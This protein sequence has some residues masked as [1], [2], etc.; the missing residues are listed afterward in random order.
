[1]LGQAGSLAEAQTRSEEGGLV[2]TT[3]ISMRARMPSH[4][5]YPPLVV[6]ANY[7]HDVLSH[8]NTRNR[9]LKGS[10][11]TES[12]RISSA[13]RSC[14]AGGGAEPVRKV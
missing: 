6:G 1:M 9:W 14:P 13:R 4:L 7:R 8:L 2:S 12:K 11:K 3:K 10:Q 5:E